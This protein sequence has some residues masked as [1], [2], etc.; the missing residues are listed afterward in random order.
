MTKR[1]RPDGFGRSASGNVGRHKGRS[2]TVRNNKW[3][4][5]ASGDYTMTTWHGDAQLTYR[6][7]RTEAGW[8]VSRRVAGAGQLTVAPPQE[9]LRA[10]KSRRKLTRG[11][12]CSDAREDPAAFRTDIVS[13]AIAYQMSF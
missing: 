6:A 8:V 11:G 5:L 1:P 2:Y 7:V 3:Y 4:K 9:T 13:V 10:A 12:R